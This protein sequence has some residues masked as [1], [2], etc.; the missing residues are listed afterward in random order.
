M[1]TQF[2]FYFWQTW[3]IRTI[4]LQTEFAEGTNITA[5]TKGK[6]KILSLKCR[7]RVSVSGCTSNDERAASKM[8]LSASV[9]SLNTHS[10]NFHWMFS[11]D[12]G[13]SLWDRTDEQTFV[14]NL[15]FSGSEGVTRTCVLWTRIPHGNRKADRYCGRKQCDM[16]LLPPTLH[17]H[18][19]TLMTPWRR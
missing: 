4:W 16:S 9:A 8:Y 17:T 7:N 6:F 18:S 13:R 12:T 19:G 11:V 15:T 14:L 2:G 3:L 1:S 10:N 5:N